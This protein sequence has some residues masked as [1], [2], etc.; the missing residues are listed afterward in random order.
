MYVELHTRSAF[1]FLEGGSLPEELI[2]ACASQSMR[3]VAMLDRDGVYG[4]PR[5]H[6]A[7]RKAGVRAHI[8]AE[9]SV[10]DAGLQSVVPAW[11]KTPAESQSVRYSLLAETAEGYR[12][13]CRLITQY[14]LREKAKGEGRATLEELQ[15]YAKGLVC[16]T[17][18]AEGPLAAALM[19]G[20][21][22]A[23][24][25]EVE[26][27]T[28]IFGSSNVLVELQR[29]FDRK[30]E[31]RNQAA[32][33]IARGL[34]LPLLATNGVRYVRPEDRELLDVLTCVR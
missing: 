11:I 4:A 8:G 14:K 2:S 24:R 27:L 16:L 17:G 32:V 15:S 34:K 18:G 1:S 23:A 30:E 19:S 6:M 26:R 21:Y 7:A 10:Q 33:R 22:D 29:H 28:Q 25:I 3:A 9:V 31:F 20:G 12:N 5:F 13:L